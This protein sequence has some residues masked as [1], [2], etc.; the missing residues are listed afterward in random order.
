VGDFIAKTD[1]GGLNFSILES[2]GSF[3][4]RIHG[5][6]VSIQAL[7][8]NFLWIT[9]SQG[10]R[11][12]VSENGGKSWKTR[13]LPTES[14]IFDLKFIDRQRVLA[15]SVEGIWESFDAGITW[16]EKQKISGNPMSLYMLPKTSEYYLV[17]D[18]F[19]KV[20]L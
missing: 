12:L 11:F 17:G 3:E 10:N 15:L 18:D 16:K 2:F 7:D 13:S 20:S 19:K 4:G 1:D 8:K 5:I 14:Q 9:G 6:T